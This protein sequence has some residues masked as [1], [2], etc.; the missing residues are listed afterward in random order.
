MK[1]KLLST[2]C[3]FEIPSKFSKDKINANKNNNSTVLKE[4]EK[5]APPAEHAKEKG[6][7][8]LCFLGAD[9]RQAE[10]SKAPKQQPGI[11]YFFF[12]FASSIMKAAVGTPCARALQTCLR[13]N[14]LIERNISLRTWFETQI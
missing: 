7:A 2:P 12:N 8:W 1:T 10:L 6:F 9:M 11:F 13:W 3:L 14:V 5:A 4:G